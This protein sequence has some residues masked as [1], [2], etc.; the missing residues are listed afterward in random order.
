MRHPLTISLLAALLLAAAVPAHAAKN[1]QDAAQQASRQN[2]NA[3]VLSVKEQKQG[4]N[5]EYRVKVLTK[6]GVVKTVRVPKDKD[7][8]R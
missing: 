2:N 4:K 7:K 6:D 8:N 3:K 1:K 5:E